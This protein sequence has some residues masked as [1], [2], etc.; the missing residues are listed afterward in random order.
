MPHFYNVALGTADP[1]YQVP[2]GYWMHRGCMPFV[3][4][5]QFESHN[6]PTMKPIIEELLRQGHQTLF[7][8]EGD[9]GDHLHSFTELPDDSIVYHVD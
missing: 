2:I 8:A 6:W 1:N 7:Y 4:C 3:S 5:G 9:W